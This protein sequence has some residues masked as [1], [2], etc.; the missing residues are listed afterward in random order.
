MVHLEKFLPLDPGK[1]KEFIVAG[2][3]DQFKDMRWEICGDI[4]LSYAPADKLV[5]SDFVLN[6]ADIKRLQRPSNEPYLNMPIEA[7]DINNYLYEYTKKGEVLKS[8]EIRNLLHGNV[9][10]QDKILIIYG[11]ATAYV[12]TIIR[13]EDKIP[14]FDYNMLMHKLFELEDSFGESYAWNISQPHSLDLLKLLA[15]RYKHVT[16]VRKLED[17]SSRIVPNKKE[18]MKYYRNLRKEIDQKRR[19]LYDKNLFPPITERHF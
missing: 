19:P 13:K 11:T 10:L 8:K 15:P 7:I 1:R 6:N 2:K 18:F 5:P 17:L 16:G 4:H 14:F 9:F 3:W 12:K